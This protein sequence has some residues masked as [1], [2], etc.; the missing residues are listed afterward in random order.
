MAIPYAHN[1]GISCIVISFSCFDYNE[2]EFEFIVAISCR[3]LTDSLLSL[4]ITMDIWIRCGHFPCL[5]KI[6]GLIFDKLRTLLNTY[7]Y[8]GKM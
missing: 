3:I 2:H 4:M 5:D 7:C 1:N 8:V 6:F